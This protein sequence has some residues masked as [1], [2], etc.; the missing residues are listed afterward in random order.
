MQPDGSPNADRFTRIA[1]AFSVIGGKPPARLP[2]LT[3]P[4]DKV[5][6]AELKAI[7]DTVAGEVKAAVQPG[8]DELT[9][10]TARIDALEKQV[11]DMLAKSSEPR[12]R[13]SARREQGGSDE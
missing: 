2:P 1:G 8:A 3:P 4:V 6:D 13:R 12:A 10:A 7:R 9:K 11:K 5:S